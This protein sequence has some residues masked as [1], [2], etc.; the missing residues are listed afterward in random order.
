MPV[1]FT[2]ARQ[3][4]LERSIELTGSVD[5]RRTSL[6]ASEVEGLVTELEA[7]E[8]DRVEKGRVLVRLRRTGVA[9]RLEAAE[10]QL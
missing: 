10:G 9:L 5:S 2:E 7:R 3:H 4:R 1:R 8:G 6:V